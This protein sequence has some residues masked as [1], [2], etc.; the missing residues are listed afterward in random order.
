MSHFSRDKGGCKLSRS[1]K[2]YNGHQ[3]PLCCT[4]NYHGPGK[5]KPCVQTSFQHWS[6]VILPWDQSGHVSSYYRCLHDMHNWDQN[7]W[8]IPIP[9]WPTLENSHDLLGA[10]WGGSDYSQNW[11]LAR[12]S[13]AS[14][15][16]RIFA[17]CEIGKI[18]ENTEHSPKLFSNYLRLDSCINNYGFGNTHGYKSYSFSNPKANPATRSITSKG[19]IHSQLSACLHHRHR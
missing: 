12:K 17:R 18:C 10:T 4:D 8:K 13:R 15:L 14:R 2:K 5:V 6:L 16:N 3:K 9:R 7:C 11:C 19:F 1:C